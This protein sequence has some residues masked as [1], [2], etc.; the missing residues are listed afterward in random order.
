MLYM[1]WLRL[2]RR[3]DRKRSEAVQRHPAGKRIGR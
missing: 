1:L 3:Y 2:T